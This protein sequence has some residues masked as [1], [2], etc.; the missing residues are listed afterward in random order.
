MNVLV[1]GSGG[2]E[3]ALVWKLRQSPHVETIFCAPGNAGIEQLATLVQLK[4]TDV[5][6]LLKFSK[7]KKIDL[8]VVGS[9]QP[10]VEGLVDVFEENGFKVFGPSKS[11]AQLEGSKSFSKD[12]MV[13]HHIPTAQ[14][15]NFAATAYDE[16]K[17][18]I[19]TLDPPMVVKADGLAAG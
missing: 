3:H 7:E 14:Y 16:A 13:R 2:R 19:N 5:K 17:N 10:L 15:R 1:I 4:P 18:Y 9:E 12:F 11:A 8:T 6:G